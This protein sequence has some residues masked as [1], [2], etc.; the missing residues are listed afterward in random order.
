MDLKTG[1]TIHKQIMTPED[2][3]AQASQMT[4]DKV[5]SYYSQAAGIEDKTVGAE[6]ATELSKI[7]HIPAETIAAMPLA[8]W[9][10]VQSGLNAKATAA[11]KGKLSAD[12]LRE[13][14]ADVSASLDAFIESNPKL[15]TFFND[16][17]KGRKNDLKTA[18]EQLYQ[19]N[20]EIGPDAAVAAIMNVL[21]GGLSEPPVMSD[22]NPMVTISVE[23]LGPLKLPKEVY[24]TLVTLR[25]MGEFREPMGPAAPGKGISDY[26]PDAVPSEAVPTA[27]PPG[28]GSPTRFSRV[29]VAPPQYGPP[30]PVRPGTNPPQSGA[31]TRF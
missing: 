6:A 20:V 14:R 29:P 4:P 13:A 28:S 1:K 23:G 19:N 16:E 15:D 25:K 21:T 2:I 18:T 22:D 24:K 31:R 17:E 26:M 30:I 8:E 9:E 3:I 12:N 11:D 7:Y 27:L 10:K 5:V